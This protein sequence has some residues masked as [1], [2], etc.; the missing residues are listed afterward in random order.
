MFVKNLTN[1]TGFSGDLGIQSIPN[2]YAA[3]YVM[4]PRTYGIGLH[5][6]F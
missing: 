4:R 1:E 2:S 5:Y 6:H 3:R